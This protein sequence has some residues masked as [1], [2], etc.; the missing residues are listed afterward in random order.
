[1]L[2]SKLSEKIAYTENLIQQKEQYEESIDKLQIDL[3]EQRK[4]HDDE[5]QD[6]QDLL[7]SKIKE[8][9][10]AHKS[11]EEIFKNANNKNS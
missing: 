1:M 5:K 11:S 3:K 4:L 10:E 9:D 6:L 8:L 2:N 7:N